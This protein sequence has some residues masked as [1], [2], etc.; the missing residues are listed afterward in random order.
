MIKKGLIVLVSIGCVLSVVGLIMINQSK[1][2][3]LVPVSER[4]QEVSDV[5]EIHS[6]DGQELTVYEMSE[7]EYEK[8]DFRMP[9]KVVDDETAK[10]NYKQTGNV[11]DIANNLSCISVDVLDEIFI[12]Y[13]AET[14]DIGMVL[15]AKDYLSQE[16][17]DEIAKTYIQATKDFGILEVLEGCVSEEAMKEIK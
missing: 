5:V 8:T 6:S 10:E 17:L 7:E 16:V 13:I 12:D 1:K 15:V 11:T 2:N 14:Q 9:T 4:N 3:E